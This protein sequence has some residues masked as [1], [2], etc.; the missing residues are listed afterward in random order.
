MK[1]LF[2][3]TS[4]NGMAQRAWL[5]L[6]RLDHQVKVHIA[7]DD[8]AM[9]E[10]AK[11]FAPELI[12]APFLKKKIPAEIWK[13]HT[14]LIIHPG[15]KGDRGASSLDWAI[16][17]REDEWGVTILQASEKMDAGPIWVSHRF[18]MR[19]V[20][21]ACL[22][23]HEVTQAAMKGLMEAVEK[24]RDETFKPQ[25][26]DYSDPG[27][28]GGW[29]RSTRQS[30]FAFSWSDATDD[31]ILKIRAADSDPGVFTEIN[32]TQY[33]CY[34][35]HREDS[36]RGKAGKIIA[37]RN[38][39]ICVGTGEEAVWITHLKGVE[40]G[41]I[42]L[43]AAVTM[44]EDVKDIPEYS[45]DPFEEN[46]GSTFREIYYQEEGEVGFLHF[47]FYNGAM[48]TDQ[49]KRLQKTFNKAKQR[50]VKV[51]VLMGGHD[52]WSNGIHLN[53][54]EH[55]E[56]AADES[57]ANINAIDDLIEEII[58]STD[59]FII[60]AM[61]GNAGA[62]GVPLAL[63]A[64]KVLARKGIV[65]NPHTR[66]MGL[67]GS[68]YWTYLLPRRIGIEK[69]THFTEQCLP[70]GTAVAKEIGLID[71]AFETTA[72]AFRE[73]VRERAQETAQLSWFDKLIAS[74]R[75]QRRKDEAVKS[76]DDYREKE[77]SA[78]KKNFY[79]NNRDYHLKRYRF[80]HKIHEPSQVQSLQGKD[81]YSSRRKIYRKYKTEKINYEE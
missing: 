22:Y 1:I 77:L 66:Q 15:I 71:D 65:L 8:E 55:A 69:A 78:M 5:E 31:I 43:P 21:K 4:F 54:I 27:V 35:A 46:N 36:L 52:V 42:K 63:A 49:C 38:E 58:L 44:G 17:N 10:A 48:S 67:Y 70:W 2:I 25:L 80:V 73:E 39:A 9:I 53:V 37:Q 3:T 68:E 28:N 34:G 40:K 24:F 6:D 29:K 62:G 81:L 20:S 11:D 18:D 41:A 60:S 12:I 33:Y 64:D 26:L 74:K 32:E 56:S 72:A 79:D 16:L 59:H 75:F 47:N 23:R 76:L 13:N 61:Q 51:I 50:P 7:G 30:D 14:C 19:P 57:L 45:L